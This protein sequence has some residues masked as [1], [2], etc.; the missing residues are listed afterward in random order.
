[1]AVTS[2]RHKRSSPVL[3][4]LV[5]FAGVVACSSDQN[6]SPPC[7]NRQENIA[8]I[9]Q[10]QDWLTRHREDLDID[11]PV[12]TSCDSGSGTYVWAKVLR[13]AVLNNWLNARGC[14]IQQVCNAGLGAV[15]SVILVKEDLLT[16]WPES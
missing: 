3:L 16:A 13:R 6:D 1:M 8:N 4:C 2:R 9:E 15:P 5:A 12:S 14:S 10:I 7:N 11:I